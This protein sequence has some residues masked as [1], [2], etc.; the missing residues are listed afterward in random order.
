LLKYLKGLITE[1]EFMQKLS[2]ERAAYLAM[3][4]KAR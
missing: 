1:A 3:F 2:V 4:Q